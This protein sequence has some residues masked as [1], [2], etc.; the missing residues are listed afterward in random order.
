[1]NPV[2]KL[3]K[4]FN[5]E[6][7]RRPEVLIPELLSMYYTKRPKSLDAKTDELV[8]LASAVDNK[9]ERCVSTHYDAALKCGATRDA[10]L[11]VI[12]IRIQ[13]L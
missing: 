6:M 1:M 7:K 8:A 11:D 12:L 3:F 4:A 10:I 13:L 2:E 9:S 5:E